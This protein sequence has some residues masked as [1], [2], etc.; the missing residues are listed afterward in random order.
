MS[1]VVKPISDILKELIRR[2]STNAKI[3]KAVEGGAAMFGVNEFLGQLLGGLS[4]LE[5]QAEMSSGL[6]MKYD[7]SDT[8]ADS[9]GK[10]AMA[11]LSDDD[12][13][14]PRSRESGEIKPI[15]YLVFDLVQGRAWGLAPGGYNSRKS[16]TA[17][18]QRGFSG[19]IRAGRR[20]TSLTNRLSKGR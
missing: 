6:Q 7:I 16:I 2:A 4:E 17:S 20:R 12:M 13:L 3:G 1:G 14:L 10:V 9:I 18:R 19:G 8:D 11:I 15:Q 5:V